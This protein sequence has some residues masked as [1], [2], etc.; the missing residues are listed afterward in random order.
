MIEAPPFT[1]A[2]STPFISDIVG[3]EVDEDLC[4]LVTTACGGN[5]LLISEFGRLLVESGVAAP[6]EKESVQAL[7]ESA[8]GRSMAE[9]SSERRLA[10]LPPLER[11]V[12]EHLAMLRRPVQVALLSRPVQSLRRDWSPHWST[13]T[14]GV[15]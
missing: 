9:S 2:E 3:A 5:P 6:L 14:R 1:S 15:I 10:G 12:L 4:A 13:S 7:I 11:K 8:Q